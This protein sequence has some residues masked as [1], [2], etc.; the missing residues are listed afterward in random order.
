MVLKFHLLA[1]L[2]NGQSCWDDEGEEGQLESV[3][4]LNAEN[5]KSHW[6]ESDGLQEDEYN[7]GDDDF[8]KF[9]FAS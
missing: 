8:P 9:R 6:N 2:E 5:S 4:S 1:E 3:P 7:D